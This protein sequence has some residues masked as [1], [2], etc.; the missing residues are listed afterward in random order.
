MEPESATMEANLFPKDTY[1]SI[2]MVSHGT[3]VSSSHGLPPNVMTLLLS[4]PG[5]SLQSIL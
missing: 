3:T 2:S 4:A 1:Q 5:P